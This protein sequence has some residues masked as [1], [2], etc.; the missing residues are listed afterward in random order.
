MMMEG[1]ERIRA[2]YRQNYD[3]V[4]TVKA[5]YDPDNTFRINQNVAPAG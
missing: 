3:R 1:Q 2:A 4:A 5:A